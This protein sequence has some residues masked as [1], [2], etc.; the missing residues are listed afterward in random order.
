ML[1]Q[2]LWSKGSLHFVLS[3]PRSLVGKWRLR[4]EPAVADGLQGK[5]CVGLLL[6]WVGNVAYYHEVLRRAAN[7][8]RPSVASLGPSRC[9]IFGN[10]EQFAGS[11]FCCGAI[12]NEVLSDFQTMTNIEFDHEQ[13][14]VLQTINSLPDQSMMFVRALAG[15]GKT[16]VANGIIFACLKSRRVKDFEQAV[17]ILLPS[18]VLR[19]DI[20]LELTKQYSVDGEAI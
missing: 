6:G 13:L 17:L 20:V 15:T 2:R 3:A 11:N 5:E 1:L 12:T 16:A 7:D 14:A 8:E 19:E 9:L 10:Q 18:R 4:F